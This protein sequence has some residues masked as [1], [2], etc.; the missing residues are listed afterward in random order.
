[1]TSRRGWTLI[2]LVTVIVVLGLLSMISVLKY[3]DLTRTGY[4]A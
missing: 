3:I 1:M 4:A 2:E